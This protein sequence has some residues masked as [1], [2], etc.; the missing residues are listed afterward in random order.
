MDVDFTPHLH[1]RPPVTYHPA[2]DPHS[3]PDGGANGWEGI[4]ALTY[5]GAP[6]G[7]KKT[8]VF[9][10]I[11][12]PAGASATGKVPGVVLVHGGGGHAF[13]EWIRIWNDRGYAAIA[14]DT[15]GCYPSVTGQGRAGRES[16]VLTD[17]WCYGL[18][19]PFAEEGYADAP[20]NDEMG[21]YA[22]PV[23]RQWMYHAIAATMG[24]RNILSADER[25]DAARIGITGI[26]WGG[27]ITSLVMG[28]DPHY[29]FAIPI[30]GSAYLDASLG[31]MGPLF[32]QPDT[33]ANWS[34]ADRLERVTCPVLWLCW[35]E[36]TP[37]SVNSVSRSYAD[38]KA[39]GAR[40]L[41]KTAMGHSHE[42]GWTPEESYL[43]ADAAVGRRP[44]L[45]A[46]TEEPV[47][48]RQ[49][50]G[51]YRLTVGIR[52]AADAVSVTA[53][54]QYITA[55]LSYCRR[56]EK[57]TVMEQTWQTAPLC[58]EGA[59]VSGSLPAEA[60]DVTVTVTTVTA[61]GTYEISSAFVQGLGEN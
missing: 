6:I 31:W 48:V 45:T 23:E 13:A 29:T 52:P 18:Y 49:P 32:S 58:V 12:F 25:V 36:D 51:T 1:R 4:R 34:A 2:F 47:A 5:E 10:Y 14:M 43:F 39:A 54:A 40:F 20:N 44:A 56:S 28:Y 59:A 33:K 21:G 60:V 42:C 57:D 35:A 24:A 46:V 50:D 9:A 30:Y 15:T 53:V 22:L 41:A 17:L 19:G 16:D 38:T 8:K 27:V 11:G 61:D 26:S 3:N 37:F 7:D 55:P